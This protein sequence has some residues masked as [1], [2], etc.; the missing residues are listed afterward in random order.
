MKKR[1]QT[2]RVI[3]HHSL[4][5]YG[6]IEDVRRWH[7]D[8]P[9]L[10]R[11]WSDVGYSFIVTLDGN[12]QEGR[13]YK[14]QGAHAFGKNHDSIGVCLIGNFFKSEPTY[15]QIETCAGLYHRLCRIYSKSL[16]VEFHRPKWMWNACPGP[17]LDRYDLKEQCAKEDPYGKIRA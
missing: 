14:L 6:T 3:F 4:S 10:G 2:N 15:Q 16:K 1:K 11:G 5:N 9:P 13:D 7:T 8:A 12:V 17:R